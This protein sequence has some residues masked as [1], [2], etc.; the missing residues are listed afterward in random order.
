MSGDP[1][2]E[3][4]PG[5][6]A[7]HRGCELAGG[8]E[9]LEREFDAGQGQALGDGVPQWCGGGRQ[10][11]DVARPGGGQHVVRHGPGQAPRHPHDAHELAHA[12]PAAV[13]SAPARGLQ[14]G[15]RIQRQGVEPYARLRDQ[16]LEAAVRHQG[17]LVSRPGQG[18]PQSGV[19]GHIAPRARRHDRYA[20]PASMAAPPESSASHPRQPSA[21]RGYFRSV[22]SVDFPLS[23]LYFRR[24]A[25]GYTNYIRNLEHPE[26]RS[27]HEGAA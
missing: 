22:P 14:L 11:Q 4:A 1:V 10:E 6:A 16:P 2:A 5:A 18:V 13:Q 7:E 24:H 20:H 15:P 21:P 8:G 19:G 27:P 17:H 25:F 12:G 26:P 23:W 9:R 3:A